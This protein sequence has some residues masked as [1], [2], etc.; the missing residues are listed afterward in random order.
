MII[1]EKYKKS[2]LII[3]TWL[4]VCVVLTYQ[5]CF[6]ILSFDGAFQ[7]QAAYNWWTEGVYRVDYERMDTQTRLPF[8]I[9]NGFFLVFFGKTFL[10]ANFANILFYL[11]LILLL[12]KLYSRF[13]RE[14]NFLL[15]LVALSLSYGVLT[16]GFD[17]LGEVP[18]ITMLL[19]G[20][21]F[22]VYREENNYNI[23]LSGFCIGAGLATKWVGFLVAA[24]IT[25]TLLLLFLKKEYKYIFFLLL[26]IGITFLSFSYLQYNYK[27][28]GT[29]G[30]GEVVNQGLPATKNNKQEYFSR[31]QVF[32]SSYKEGSLFTLLAVTKVGLLV[33]LIFTL[34]KTIKDVSI[35]K[36][37][38]SKIQEWILII[39][40]YT[41]VYYFWW[42][43]LGA[44]P[45]YRRLFCAD[46]LLFISLSFISL[47]IFKNKKLLL[48]LILGL[49]ITG[50]SFYFFSRFN[51]T[52]KEKPDGL[53]VFVLENKMDNAL[54]QL[55]ID[56]KGYGYG[57]WQAPRWAF[58]GGKKF[59]NV[60]KLN[61]NAK[62]AIIDPVLKDKHYLFTEKDNELDPSSW[63]QVKELLQIGEVFDYEDEYEVYKIESFKRPSRLKKYID[64]GREDYYLHEGI[65][66]WER[67]FCWSKQHSTIALDY[68]YEKFLDI[69]L[70]FPE[71]EKYTKSTVTLKIVVDDTPI[72]THNIYNS[73]RLKR[74]IPLHNLIGNKGLV[75]VEFITDGHLIV[76]E[77]R[78]NLAFMLY[79]VGFKN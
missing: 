68:D 50:H 58:I 32:F 41:L 1:F 33:I 19:W 67:P 3:I 76:A 25:I 20:L 22:L 69:D 24:P 17:G 11:L 43:F 27:F 45:W 18:M 10:V 13:G 2:V 75:K 65:Y 23:F 73:G 37:A 4:V 48:T 9:I 42:F 46:I 47:S 64:F 40:T 57:W 56:Y 21:Y 35:Q 38:A 14:K 49:F 26:M 12:F 78:R 29:A 63:N 70:N 16:F 15:A 60:F 5:L 8:Q 53:D 7:A 34:L 39:I 51:D 61:L 55:P 6:S 72:F 54:N 44:K 79:K 74:R 28:V 30:L 36:F 77:D 66:H 31:L 52:L 62:L 59:Q 71:F